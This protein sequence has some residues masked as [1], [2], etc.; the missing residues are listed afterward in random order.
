[1]LRSDLGLTGTKVGCN[2][3]DCGA[4]TVLLDGRQ[5]C[6]CLVSFAQASGR[7]VATVEGLACDPRFAGLQQAF[8][9]AGATQ[10]GICTPGMLMAAAELALLP[11]PLSRQQVLDRMGGV[12]CRC[13]GYVRIVDAVESFLGR[14]VLPALPADDARGVVGTRYRKVDAWPRVTGEARFGADG[15]PQDALWLRAIRSHLPH[16]RFRIG[17]TG[18]M[19]GRH[20][21]IVRV[22]AAADVPGRNAFCIF[23]RLRDQPVLAEGYVRYLGEAVA[24]IVGTRDA[25]E[26]FPVSE[27]PIEWE[28]LPPVSGIDIAIEP[29]TAT[30]H[31]GRPGNLLMQGRQ[32]DGDVAARKGSRFVSG[33]FDT[34]FV[35]HAY[36]EPEAGFARRDGDRITLCVPTQAPYMNRDEIASI[37]GIEPTAVRVSPT[38]VGGGFGGKIDMSLQPLIAVAAWLVPGPVACIYTR[39]E[40]MRVTTKRHPAAMSATLSCDESGRLATYEFHADFNT[41]PYSSCGPIVGS[42]VPIHAMGPYRVPAVHCTTR[43]IHTTD[44][45][46]GAFRGFGVPQCAIVHESLMDELAEAIGVDRFEF[47]L[48]NVL[49]DGD[50][51]STGQVLAHSVGMRACLEKLEPAWRE[52]LARVEQFNATAG[53]VRLGLGIGCM[54]YGIGNTSQPNPSTIRIGI[55]IGAGGAARITLFSGAVDIGQGVSTVLVQMCADA[56][57]VSP[58]EIDLIAGVG[59]T[60]LTLDAGKSSASRHTFISGNALL[61]AAATLQAE[62]RALAGA[63]DDARVLFE[64]GQVLVEDGSGRR[65]VDLSRLPAGEDGMRISASGYFNPPTTD[66]DE[67][68]QGSPYASYAFGA[69]LALVEV[70]TVLA[71]TRVRKIWAAHDVGRA[72]NPAQVEGQIHGGIAQGLGLALMEEYLPGRTDNL[73]DYL[74]PTFGDMPE[75]EIF[76]V[77]AAE[78]LGP[79]GAKGV[80]EPA[81]I[82]TAPAILNAI[83]HATGVRP[84]RAPVT[85]S[86]LWELLHAHTAG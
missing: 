74:I 79:F 29:G 23:P 70:D 60:D 34:S 27:F 59:D 78:P 80:G 18:S 57:G 56:L 14:R 10:C 76:I 71:T 46:G 9:D 12:L 20:P 31:D 85:P 25:V 26:A 58:A 55:G 11:G 63:S 49:Q 53:R 48:R 2:A 7:S 45:I 13:T 43:A 65:P 54:W 62:L 5:V 75:V 77:E 22:L 37:L 64:R 50:R 32:V 21:G 39:G 40:S 6:S 38:A 68:H 4:C 52:Q 17:D 42:R 47:R 51:T 3:G 82:P 44:A 61:L 28:P 81:L 1:V 72:I 66:L 35:E 16:A 69:Q 19:L 15:F 41:G 83:A 67:H 84:R 30:L 8:V 73:H 86:R 33:A 36:I 24:A